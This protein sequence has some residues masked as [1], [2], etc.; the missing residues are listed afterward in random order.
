VD[1]LGPLFVSPHEPSRL[2]IPIV[3]LAG[4]LIATGVVVLIRGRLPDI[5]S[6]SGVLV[7][8]LVAYAVGNLHLLETSK[9]VEFCGSCHQ[10]MSPLVQ[11]MRTRD[12]HLAG[13]H[14]RRGAVSHEDACFRCHSG[15]GLFGNARAKLSGIRH[16]VHTVTSDYEFPLQL[17]EPLDIAS[18]LDCHAAAA[19]FREA[20]AHRDPDLQKSLL[21]GEISCAG[22]CHLPAHPEE[23]LS[24]A[25]AWKAAQ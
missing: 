2:W 13:Y 8:P 17:V 20:E 12:D 23:A 9:S 11:A 15:Y 21:S 7:L 14:F 19:P 3:A 25:P 6:F 1:E 16:M 18:C 4:L 5:F 22:L 10:L 24:G